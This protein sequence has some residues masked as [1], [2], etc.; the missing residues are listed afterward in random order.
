MSGGLLDAVGARQGIVAF[1]GAGGKKTTLYALAAE[2]PGRLGITTTTLT[3]RFPRRAGAHPVVDDT[4]DLAPQ[5][6]AAARTHRRVA[7]ARTSTKS[8]RVGGIDAALVGACHAAARFEATYVKAD[9]ARMRAIKAPAPD[10]PAIPDD[11]DTV[12]FL[13]SAAAFGAPLDERIA[14]R[15]ERLAA[16]TGIATG[17]T[18]DATAVSRLL[19]SP[20][21]ALQRVPADARLVIVINAVDDDAREAQARSAAHAALAATSRIERV[22]LTSHR[23]GAPW[24][25]VIDRA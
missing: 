4:P 9:G 18:I 10:E 22:V 25:E 1:V 7:F 16:V 21:G 14:H 17:D 5:V 2:H 24:I 15:P 8:G 12:V 23:R 19:A 11:T 3:P 13:V 6:A 20:A